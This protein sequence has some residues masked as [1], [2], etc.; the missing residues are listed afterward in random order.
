MDI[1]VKNIYNGILKIFLNEI[2]VRDLESGLQ[3]V[4]YKYSLLFLFC[5][6]SLVDNNFCSCIRIVIIINDKN[7][8]D[9]Y[10]LLV[11]MQLY[12]FYMWKKEYFIGVIIIV[13]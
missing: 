13:L 8:L 9:R 6:F 2:L 1:K 7:N 3:E 5:K 10:V 4:L 12:Y 11:R